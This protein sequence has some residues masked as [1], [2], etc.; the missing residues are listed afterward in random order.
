MGRNR[1]I[2]IAHGEALDNYCGRV[3]AG[4]PVNHEHFAMSY[5]DFIAVTAKESLGSGISYDTYMERQK[6]LDAE[7]DNCLEEIFGAT[8]LIKSPHL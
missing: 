7:V 6:Q 5:A 3:L 4:L 1:D 8:N 2:H